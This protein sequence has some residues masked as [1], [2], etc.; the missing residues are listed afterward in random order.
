MAG[1]CHSAKPGMRET[2]CD[3]SAVSANCCGAA[4]YFSLH[5]GVKELSCATVF[6]A[7]DFCL[8]FHAQCCGVSPA[9][10]HNWSYG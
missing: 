7:R 3:S 1:V 8:D 6:V 5:T 4:R 9:V 10:T 2:C